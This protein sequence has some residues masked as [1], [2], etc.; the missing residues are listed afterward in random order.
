MED[1]FFK[2]SLFILFLVL[3]LAGGIW[4]APKLC[5][6]YWML[7][8]ALGLFVSFFLGVLVLFALVMLISGCFVDLGKEQK[9][10]S[11]WF[12]FLID[13]FLFMGFLFGGVRIHKK[14]LEL[15]PRG[16]KFLLVS[17]HIYD[18]DPAIFIHCMPWA[19]LG[20]ISKKENYTM[21]YVNKVMHRLHCLPIDRENDRAALKTILKAAEILKTCD[22]SMA[23]FPEGYESKTGELLPF[24]NG[25]F[26]IAQRAGVS[27]VVAVLRGTKDIPKNMFRRPTHVDMEILG[28]IPAQEVCNVSTQVVGDRAHLMMEKALARKGAV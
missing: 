28:V 18:F 22:H 7:P 11:R 24:R 12:S 10:R 23:V 4:L 16:E 17:N 20:F 19:K 26:K 14:G 2:M 25:A 27:V 1:A 8:C 9:T 3:S 13:Q 15:V 21:F 6:G 5:A